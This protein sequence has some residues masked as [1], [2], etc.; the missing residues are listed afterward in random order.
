MLR[1]L[2]EWTRQLNWQ[3]LE[4]FHKLANLLHLHLAGILNYCRTK[5][6]LGVVEAVNGNIKALLRRGPRLLQPPLPAP[7]GAAHG[8]N[9]HRIHRPPKSRLKCAPCQI[10]V[11]SRKIS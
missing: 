2:G 10:L 1:Y 6:R 4:P 7:Q 3:R 8:R 9:T 11:Q 5:V